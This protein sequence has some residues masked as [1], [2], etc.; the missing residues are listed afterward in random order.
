M[1]KQKTLV[2]D[3]SEGPVIST[4]LS[5]AWPIM[6][7]NALQAVYNLVDMIVVGQ[8]VG[9]VGLSAVGIG[10]QIQMIF[11]TFGMGFASGAQ[12]VISQQVGIKSDRIDKSIGTL[13]TI[14][15]LMAIVLGMVGIFGHKFLLGF[16]NTPDASFAQASSYTVICSIGMIF[17]FEYNALC[18]I[19]RGMGES[20]LPMVF[21]G[22]ASMINVILDII[23]VGPLHKGAGGAAAATVIAQGAA[24]LFA[25]VYLYRHQDAANFHFSRKAFRIDPDQAKSL[26]RL[27]IPSVFQML[28]ITASLAFV[29]SRVNLYNVT[30]SAVDSVG[31]KMASVVN[32]VC[33]AIAIASSTMVAQSFAAGKIDRVK[34][35]VHSSFFIQMIWFAVIASIYLFLP[36]PLFRLFTSDSAVLAMAPLYCKIQVFWL[37]AACTMNVPYCVVKG[38][39]FASFDLFVGIMDGVVARIGLAVLLGS[40]MGLTGY[41]L[42]NSLA[43]FTTTILMGIYYLTGKWKYRKVI[44]K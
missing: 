7:A 17:I 18:A 37:L 40:Q 27:G 19:F 10:G 12:V 20:K 13:L 35:V 8:F 42:G 38:V 3:M 34:K 14:E 33:G 4:M 1:D 15:F 24:C 9:S 16:L 30:A 29:N 25:M 41:W 39:G 31:N 26:C 6:L 5:F 11:L 43:G 2:R 22:I 44:T 23:F 21:V 36:K 28:M 32:I